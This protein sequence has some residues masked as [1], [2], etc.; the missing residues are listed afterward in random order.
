MRLH[1]GGPIVS[2]I[3]HAVLRASVYR[4]VW[5]LPAAGV[6][7]VLLGACLLIVHRNQA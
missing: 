1:A 6:A 3:T 5:S 7:L 4:F 2:V